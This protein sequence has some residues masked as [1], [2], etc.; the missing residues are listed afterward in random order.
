MD[1][2][3]KPN[4]S[5]SEAAVEGHVNSAFKSEDGRA[6]DFISRGLTNEQPVYNNSRL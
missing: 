2:P 5:R 3:V 1:G 6:L 4:E